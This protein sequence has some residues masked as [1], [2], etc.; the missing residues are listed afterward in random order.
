MREIICVRSYA[1]VKMFQLTFI[2]F[3]E[4]LIINYYLDMQTFCGSTIMS[5]DG[6]LFNLE[7]LYP[8]GREQKSK[9]IGN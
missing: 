9:G 8:E 6:S 4:P 2:F 3:R 1:I 5:N 7:S